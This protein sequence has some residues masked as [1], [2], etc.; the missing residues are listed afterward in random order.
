[1]VSQCSMET[2]TIVEPFDVGKD[3]TPSLIARERWPASEQLILQGAE[4]ALSDG[5]VIAVALPAHAGEHLL[6]REPAPIGV[7]CIRTPAIRVMDESRPRPSTHERHLQGRPHQ[8]F[9]IG[10]RHGP[11]HHLAGIQIQQH[12]QIQPATAGGD[13]RDIAHPDPIGSCRMERAVQAIWRD[14]RGVRRVRRQLEAPPASGLDAVEPSQASDP[15]LAA[16]NALD[17]Q[18]LPGLAC[19][20]D[21]AGGG[22]HAPNLLDQLTIGLGPR[23][24]G[25]IPPRIVAAGAHPQRLAH[26]AN[27]ERWLLE[28]R[29]QDKLLVK[30]RGQAFDMFDEDTLSPRTWLSDL[31]SLVQSFHSS[32]VTPHSS[33]A[34]AAPPTVSAVRPIQLPPDVLATVAYTYDNVGNRLTAVSSMQS[35]VSSLTYAYDPLSQ[36]DTVTEPTQGNWNYDY[37]PVG[38]RT[39]VIEPSGTTPYTPNAL[40]QYTSVGVTPYTYDPN[41]N[42][43]NDGVGTY[44]YDAE[45]RLISS[46]QS[47][48]SSQYKYDAFGRRIE[49]T[50]NGVTTK[51]TYDGD[52]SVE[53]LD[54]SG[55]QLAEYI[56]GPGIDEPIRMQRG[57]VKTYFLADGLGSITHL[58]SAQG[59]IV[60][61][62]Q[63]D[64]YGKPTILDG[65]GNPLTTSAYGN[66]YLFTG[67]EYDQETGTYHYRA[68]TYNALLG[69]F[70]QRDP[71]TWA[72]NDPRIFASSGVDNTLLPLLPIAQE[73]QAFQMPATRFVRR[74]VLL[75]GARL[76]RLHIAY[77][78]VLN[79]PINLT[80]PYGLWYID[81]NFSFGFGPSFGFLGGT[82][83]FIISPQ[84]IYGYGGPG[85]SSSGPSGSITWSPGQVV[86]G[87]TIAG[88]FGAGIAYQKG[89]SFGEGGGQFWEVGIGTPGVSATAYYVGEP[90]VWP[91]VKK[92]NGVCQN[93]G[94]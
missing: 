81:F 57:S 75:T 88:Q 7:C 17:A 27:P 42:L 78:Y 67:R 29:G 48:I 50:V 82:T 86:K 44:T 94:Y 65:A 3:L 37:D 56:N 63:Y 87:W 61:S 91:W 22:M 46:Q 68:R 89:Y 38:N 41:G 60:E 16:R 35:A 90:W 13:K 15:M 47:A 53:E 14:P 26:A 31:A 80:D 83:G 12:G 32:L 72:P 73:M 4:E 28:F 21:A 69:G 74:N 66:R 43:T 58:T 71:Y 84:G 36:L 62:Y 25:P 45:N 5:I 6:T 79:N 23:A 18:L 70:L 20:V 9:V 11:S 52:Q 24:E 54:G 76:P 39:Q 93:D 77:P 2:L 49:K 92:G 1:M 30:K 40:N 34:E 33:L 55:T 85:F 64:A 10:L 8:P 59:A 51:F 19:P